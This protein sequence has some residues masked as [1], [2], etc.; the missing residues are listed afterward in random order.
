[1]RTPSRLPRIAGF[2]AA[3]FAFVVAPLAIPAAHAAAV[4]GT[5]T[6]LVVT[7]TGD[8]YTN[9]DVNF[10]GN[11]SVPNGSPTG[12]TFDM[13]LPA[14]LTWKGAT[15]FNLID[16]ASTEPSPANIVA[17]ANVD[18]EGHVVFTLTDYVTT[19]PNNVHGTFSFE[20]LYTDTITT[21][22]VKQ[23]EFEVNGVAYPGIPV[24]LGEPCVTD[25]QGVLP[26][27]STKYMGWM[28]AKEEML[29]SVIDVVTL[30]E[31]ASEVVVTDTPQPGSTVDCAHVFPSAG[32]TTTRLTAFRPMST[33][34]RIS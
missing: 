22:G 16:E 6:D 31:D 18:A 34:T 5:I 2:I 19:H 10:T 12:G 33:T 14:E 20:T 32:P 23:L 26:T 27:E 15:T 30:A 28:D 3:A 4:N 21:G 13:Q 7:T 11:W 9:H 24:N 1:M 17:V 29:V 8:V 25:C